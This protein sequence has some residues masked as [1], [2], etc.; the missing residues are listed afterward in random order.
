MHPAPEPLDSPTSRRER[1]GSRVTPAPGGMES[2]QGQLGLPGLVGMRDR[3]G[4]FDRLPQSLLGVVPSSV[5]ARD[6]TEEPERPP[7]ALPRPS[8]P[9]P[10]PPPLGEL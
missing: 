6:V 1:F 9:R 2:R 10:P 7:H 4:D 3:P 5:P 8:R